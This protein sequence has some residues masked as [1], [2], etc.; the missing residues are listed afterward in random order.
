MYSSS[1]SISTS[2]TTSSA[3]Y[4]GNATNSSSPQT[5][6]SITTSGNGCDTGDY[7]AAQLGYDVSCASSSAKASTSSSSMQQSSSI[8]ATSAT[9]SGR[10]SS[11]QKTTANSTTQRL[12]EGLNATVTPSSTIYNSSGTSV[13]PT[14]S[15]VALNATTTS[16]CSA[17]PVNTNDPY[18]A[19]AT[20][21]RG[22]PA[23]PPSESAQSCNCEL[24]KYSASLYQTQ[25]SSTNTQPSSTSSTPSIVL[26]SYNYTTTT[27]S[28]I[29]TTICTPVTVPLETYCDGWPRASQTCDT[30]SYN[31]TITTTYSYYGNEDDG[32]SATSTSSANTITSAASTSTASKPCSIDASDCVG[33]WASY[34]SVLSSGGNISSDDYGPHCLPPC[35]NCVVQAQRVRVLYWP[36]ATVYGFENSTNCSTTMDYFGN[37]GY[38]ETRSAVYPTPTIQG[39]NNTAVFEGQTLTSPTMYLSFED[40]HATGTIAGPGLWGSAQCG[41]SYSTAFVA[42]TPGDLSSSLSY[43]YFTSASFNPLDLIWP[44]PLTAVSSIQRS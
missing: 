11:T 9:T 21:L 40:I 35:A 20:W 26:V 24:S 30:Q 18:W 33:L 12:N 17:L 7:I 27:V 19:N 25:T 15:S 44:V 43:G 13:L 2:I 38:V 3:R 1:S 39:L 14:N 41:Q 4:Y 36:P 34:T 22:V 10:S 37:L 42:V 31:N 5:S 29:V 28:S 6:T 23:D 32:P 8:L 16:I